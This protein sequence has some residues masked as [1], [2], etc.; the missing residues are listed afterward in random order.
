MI[1]VIRLVLLFSFISM[2]GLILLGCNLISREQYYGETN[3]FKS[4]NNEI[5]IVS[6]ENKTYSAPMSGYYPATYGFENDAAGTIPTNWVDGSVGTGVFSV[7]LEITTHKNVARFYDPST[8]S[9]YVLGE[10]TFTPQTYGTIEYYIYKESGGNSA[11]YNTFRSDLDGDLDGIYLQIDV[12]NTGKFEYRNTIGTFIEFA[13]GEYADNTWFH[14]RID[15]DLTDGGYRGLVEDTYDVYLNGIKEIDGVTIMN[16]ITSID[17]IWFN[18][19]ST[20]ICTFYVDALGFSWDEKY[21][22]GD[23]LDEGLLLGFEKSIALDWLG[24]SLDGLANKTILGNST[25]P[26]PENGTHNIQVF[27]ND[28]LGAM[29][30]SNLIYFSINTP[31]PYIPPDNSL[32]IIISVAIG[33]SIA[34]G[35]ILFVVLL[36]RKRR[37]RPPKPPKP[38]ILPRPDLKIPPK[39]EKK[40][41]P[42][43]H[44]IVQREVIVIEKKPSERERLDRETERKTRLEEE[45]EKKQKRCLHCGTIIDYDDR[46]CHKCGNEQ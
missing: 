23:N 28:T 40:I 30:A 1:S 21:E 37:A 3:S 12:E 2:S 43:S 7:Q 39:Q 41:V 20:V 22:V 5:S 6:P 34:V 26:V 13:I 27:G 4:S 32:I 29:Y 10:I 25:I 9:N 45:K 16:P 33:A 44:V 36:I 24:Y 11:I 31:P 18:S 17:K 38:T 42:P 15:F 14:I 19:G 35:V 46:F 8:G